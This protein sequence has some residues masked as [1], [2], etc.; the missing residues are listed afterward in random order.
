ME[1]GKTR[2]EPDVFLA[3][4][5]FGAHEETVDHVNRKI[6]R[7]YRGCQSNQ[8]PPDIFR[9]RYQV[10]CIECAFL[11]PE[12]YADEM[13]LDD[14][15][16][17][18]THFAAY[19]MDETLVGTVRLV[20]PSYPQRYPFELHCTVFGD[21]EMPPREEAAE[22]SRLVVKKSHRRRRADNVLGVPGIMAGQPEGIEIPAAL[23]RRD[24]TS[25]MLLLGMYREMLRHS[26]QAG[27]RYWYA[28]MER[29]LVYALNKMGFRF[30]Q[31]GP[32]AD[33]YGA[34]TPYMLDLQRLGEMLDSNPILFAWLH[35]GPPVLA[36]DRPSRVHIVRNSD[37][38]P[39]I[40]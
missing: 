29:S 8:I 37:L 3:R 24:R 15:D 5:E 33:Y 2:I 18:A 34:V 20:Q 1:N 26:R 21:F 13:E 25:P 16:D 32:K 12:Q 23:D 28:A 19:T 36:T 40:D 9:L 27:I 39:N 7:S 11:Q 4:P 31:I 30:S 10:Y 22:I 35:D 38:R 14:Y 6:F 17:C